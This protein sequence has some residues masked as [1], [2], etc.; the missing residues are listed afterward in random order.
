MGATALALGDHERQGNP[1]PS[2]K[3]CVYPFSPTS[4]SAQR[5][6]PAV[7]RANVAKREPSSP[8]T[9]TTVRFIVTQARAR[10]PV[11]SS[12]HKATARVAAV[13]PP[14]HGRAKSP[15]LTAHA[16]LCPAVPAPCW[17]PF[18]RPIEMQG[19]S[20]ADAHARPARLKCRMT[21]GNGNPG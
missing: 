13:C 6:D 8:A 16:P 10:W 18:I 7:T 12:S 5:S 1:P 19:E 11:S 20:S 15:G 17:T 3:S 4:V 2:R 14:S 9:L 21:S